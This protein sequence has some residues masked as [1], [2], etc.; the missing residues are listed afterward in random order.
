MRKKKKVERASGGVVAVIGFSVS[1]SHSG[2]GSVEDERSSHRGRVTVGLC[3][4]I[5]Y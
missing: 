3:E 5:G 1:F 4:L 2:F